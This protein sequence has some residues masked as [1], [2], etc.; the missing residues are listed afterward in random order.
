MGS[1]LSPIMADVVMQDLE[2]KALERLPT[3]LPIY[4]RYVDDI[5]LAVP[6]NMLDNILKIFNSFHDRL[7]FICEVG[8]NN[9]L[10]FLNV[11]VI[12]SNHKIIF[13]LYKKPTFST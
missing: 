7:Q 13:D 3:R 9:H 1:S 6:F 10:S 2:T 11:S 8:E 5:F 4:F 12:I